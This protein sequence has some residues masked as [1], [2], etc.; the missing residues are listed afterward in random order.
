MSSH[1]TQ[2]RCRSDFSVELEVP[3][4]LEADQDYKE[5]KPIYTN[6]KKSRD[7]MNP[8]YYDW[9]SHTIQ[10]ADEFYKWRHGIV[11]D[12]GTTN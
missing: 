2:K 6:I 8:N 7:E 10:F 3:I 9:F 5:K 4:K 1:L 12:L 11:D